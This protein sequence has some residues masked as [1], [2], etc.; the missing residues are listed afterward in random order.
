MMFSLAAESISIVE[1]FM[2]VFL[3]ELPRMPLEREVEFN[4]DLLPGTIQIAKRPY[5]MAPIELT[6]SKT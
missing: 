3:E 1:E 6:K 5:Q 4:I 2:D